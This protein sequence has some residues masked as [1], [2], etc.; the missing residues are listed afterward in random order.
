MLDVINVADGR[1]LGNI[2]DLDIDMDTGQ[3]N[4]LVLSG[5]TSGFSWFGRREDIVVPWSHVVKIGV[6]VILVD[7]VR[8]ARQ[9][10]DYP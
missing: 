9:D 5:A 6:D 10:R 3:I 8:L 1:R 2:V 7:M 4:A